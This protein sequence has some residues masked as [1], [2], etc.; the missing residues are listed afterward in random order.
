[1]GEC[2]DEAGGEVVNGGIRTCL[3]G[4]GAIY[5][6]NELEWRRRIDCS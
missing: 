2:G 5:S 4:G 3:P 1:M 6:M